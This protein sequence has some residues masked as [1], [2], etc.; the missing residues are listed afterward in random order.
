M[1]DGTGMSEAG[2]SEAAPPARAERL[3]WYSANHPEMAYELAL[4]GKTLA[5]M[6]TVFG[7]NEKT[8]DRWMKKPAFRL[9][10]HKGQ[11]LADGKV[12]K[13]LYER[14][15]GYSHEAVKIFMPAGATEPV[16]APYT[17]HYPPDTAAASLWLRN[18]QGAKWRDK[19]DVEV[20]GRVTLEALVLASLEKPADS[21]AVEDGAAIEG[22]VV[23]VTLPATRPP[24]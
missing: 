18:R 15:Q 3:D 9:A 14:A 6:A 19:T 16:Y 22:Q 5:E 24:T 20:S 10:V 2:L 17:E 4:L 21:P 23:D 12:A 13:A 1:R 7:V 8:V 11:D